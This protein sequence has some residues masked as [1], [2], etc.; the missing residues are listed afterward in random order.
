MTQVELNQYMRIFR[1]FNADL[2]TFNADS[3]VKVTGVVNLMCLKGL[4]QGH[5]CAKY[6]R[7]GSIGIG[8]MRNFSDF[9]PD[10]ET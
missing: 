4:V 10:L 7:C 1:N 3:E 5:V 2:E 8:D 9:I 6:Q